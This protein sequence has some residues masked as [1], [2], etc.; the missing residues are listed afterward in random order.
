MANLTV[1]IDDE[2]LKRARLRALEQG[3]SVNAVVREALAA[4]AA[5][6]A[7]TVRALEKILSASAEAESRRGGARWTRDDLHE[8]DQ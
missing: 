4:Y 6:N 5:E 8:R 7:A 3:T 2:T 1:T